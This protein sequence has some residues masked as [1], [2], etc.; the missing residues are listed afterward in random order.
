MKLSLN[1]YS[2]HQ[3]NVDFKIEETEQ[4][5]FNRRLFPFLPKKNPFDSFK[6][7]QPGLRILPILSPKETQR[8]FESKQKNLYSRFFASFND[9]IKLLD[10]LKQEV[11]EIHQDLFSKRL[12]E[13]AE[14][15]E[16]NKS[17]LMQFI[18]NRS[19]LIGRYFEEAKAEV[20]KQSLTISHS[21]VDFL[22]LQTE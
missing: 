22:I 9:E 21:R 10:R 17:A 8:R 19:I 11:I 14:K 15:G 18:Q 16:N 4:E 12:E 1:A 6:K 20:K 5:K 7:S 2:V 3:L 13:A